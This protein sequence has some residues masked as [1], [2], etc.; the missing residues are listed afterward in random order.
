MEAYNAILRAPADR[1]PRG[2]ILPSN[3]PDFLTATKFVNALRKVN[4]AVHRATASFTVGRQVLS[5]RLVRRE[6]GAGVPSA[7]ARHVRAA[8]SP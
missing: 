4:V 3:Q 2:Y 7:R 6:V 5:G 1:N 8:G